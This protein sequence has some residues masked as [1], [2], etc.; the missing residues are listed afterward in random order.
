MIC[1]FVYIYIYRRSRPVSVGP[2]TEVLMIGV[3]ILR[4]FRGGLGTN[5]YCEEGGSE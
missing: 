4:V 1:M 2:E 5:S 3:F